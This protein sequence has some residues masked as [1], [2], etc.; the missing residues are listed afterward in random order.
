MPLEYQKLLM[1][2]YQILIMV[3]V[4]SK[5]EGWVNILSNVE[6]VLQENGC[7]DLTRNG[8]GLWWRQYGGREGTGSNGS[9]SLTRPYLSQRPPPLPNWS[10]VYHWEWVEKRLFPPSALETR[11]MAMRSDLRSR[12]SW[13]LPRWT[14]C[15]PHPSS[16]RIRSRLQNYAGT[17]MVRRSIAAITR[18]VQGS[19]N[20]SKV[21]RLHIKFISVHLYVTLPYAIYCTDVTEGSPIDSYALQGNTCTILKNA[22]RCRPVKFPI[23]GE[24][25][26]S[27]PKSAR[28]RR[29]LNRGG[30]RLRW[31]CNCIQHHI[32]NLSAIRSRGQ[33]QDQVRIAIFLSLPSSE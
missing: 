24:H 3:V 31:D 14:C 10:C 20:K 17:Y 5:L 12:E 21:I 16:V 28:S 29:G 22:K 18:G 7:Q 4:V 33:R 26:V 8:G 2:W 25:V 15:S 11:G 9:S 30:L 13:S 6:K 32:K 1:C 19:T 27:G 23:E